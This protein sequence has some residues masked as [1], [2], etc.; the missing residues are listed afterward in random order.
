MTTT[1]AETGGLVHAVGFYG[2]DREFLEMSVP[3]CEAGIAA[4][5]PTLV[6]VFPRQAELLRSVL[7][8]SDKLVFASHDEQYPHPPGALEALRTAWYDHTDG[9]TPM[10]LVG[11]LL[12]SEGLD[13]DT[14][15]RYEAAVNQELSDIPVRAMCLFDVD[16]LCDA[17][18]AELEQVHPVI[19]TTE[20]EHQPNPHYQPP[21]TF[22]ANRL[23]VV[24]D[25]LEAHPA[26]IDL[27]DPSVRAARRAVTDLGQSMDLASGQ[28]DNLVLAVSEVTTNAVVHGEPPVSVRGWGVPGRVTVRV[29][30]AGAGPEDPLAGLRPASSEGEGSGFG[31]WIAHQLCPEIAMVT[32]EDGFVVRLATGTVPADEAVGT[33][34]QNAEG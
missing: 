29:A 10:R 4:G 18:R 21:R 19:V 13:R 3:F 32:T 28:A 5:E 16:G 24:S 12:P 31:L 20:G 9:M 34:D 7:A 6:G 27:T 30:D 23:Q 2:S 8:N 22:M 1:A 17:V 14:W 15:V 33:D 26:A 11:E 25:P